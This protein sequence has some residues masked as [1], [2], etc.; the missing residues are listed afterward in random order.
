MEEAELVAQAWE[1][2]S[3]SERQELFYELILERYR[4]AIVRKWYFVEQRTEPIIIGE[5]K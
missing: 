4:R 3:E 2:L 5:Q 1:I